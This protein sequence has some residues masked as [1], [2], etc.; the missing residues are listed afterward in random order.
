[1]GEVRMTEQA[2]A[3]SKSVSTPKG[4]VWGLRG[5]RQHTDDRGETTVECVLF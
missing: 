1:M 4:D 5:E 2:R 3:D